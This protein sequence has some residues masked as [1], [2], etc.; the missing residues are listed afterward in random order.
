MFNP[1]PNA[2]S[3]IKWLVCNHFTYKLYHVSHSLWQSVFHFALKCA[4]REQTTTFITGPL[5]TCSIWSQCTSS[6]WTPKHWDSLKLGHQQSVKFKQKLLSTFLGVF[7]MIKQG[8]RTWS[9]DIHQEFPAWSPGSPVQHCS[10]PHTGR[11]P[12]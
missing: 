8:L 9:W 7:K 11:F 12:D 2:C 3:S 6:E 1:D 4:S 10:W 5:S